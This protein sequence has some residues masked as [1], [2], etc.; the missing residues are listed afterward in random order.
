MEKQD[1][2]ENLPTDDSKIDVDE[3]Y[4]VNTL[5]SNEKETITIIESLQDSLV[6]AFLFVL[7]SLPILETFIKKNVPI[8]G[9][10]VIL[11]TILKMSIISIL[12]FI[13]QNYALSQKSIF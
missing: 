12:F 4:L 1:L 13:I 8:M 3:L 11:L 5:F 6:V 10:S 9:K 2:I 7:V